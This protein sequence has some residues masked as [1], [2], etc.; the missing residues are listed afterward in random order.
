MFKML[1]IGSIYSI[2]TVI[3]HSG[4]EEIVKYR[5]GFWAIFFNKLGYSINGMMHRGDN[6]NIT[7]FIEFNKL[8]CFRWR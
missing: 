1:T 4:Y 5:L 3:Q 8:F 7:P 6:T 2:N